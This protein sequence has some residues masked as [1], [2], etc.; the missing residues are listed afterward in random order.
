MNTE[1]PYILHAISPTKFVSPFDVNMAYDSGFDKVSTY[2]NVEM[3]DI[4]DLVQ[5][6]VFSRHPNDC[7]KTGLFIAGE[8]DEKAIEM[9]E[10]AKKAMV[11]PFEISI[12]ADP[13][14][15]FT[16]AAAMIGCVKKLLKEKFKTDLKDK[17]L[18]IVGAKGIVGGACAVIAAQEG[19][20]V[21]MVIHREG[22]IEPIEKRIKNYKEKYKVNLNAIMGISD[23]EK[24]K[25][26][27]NADIILCAAKA[28]SEALLKK[29]FSSAKN[30]KIV[31]D[32]NAVPPP[33]VEGLEVN[34]NGDAI[35]GTKIYGIGALAVG[36]IKAQVQHKLLKLM[37]ESGKPVF[38]DFREAFKIAEQLKK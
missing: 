18:Q 33:G 8:D 15:S 29:H 26:S 4:N 25:M 16:T 35:R 21:G 17:V 27:E 28:G 12:F 30:L 13:A 14:G 10:K 31:S 5:D 1:K 32:V 11:P 34:F 20:K 2:T 23:D 37:C 19:A 9:M 3:D 24:T 36:Q 38:L 22:A 7:K 6:I